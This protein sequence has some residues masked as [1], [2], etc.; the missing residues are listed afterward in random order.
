[1]K[2]SRVVLSALLFV[3]GGL[4]R[5]LFVGPVPINWDAVQF[6]L[7]VERFDLH[8][9]QPHAPGYILYVLMGRA[10]N[11]LV[12]DPSVSLALLSVLASALAAPLVYLSALD[13]L[14]D[15]AVALGAA[16]LV[17]GSPL[18]LYYGSVGLTYVPEMVLSAAVGWAAWRVRKAPSIRSAMVMGALLGVAGGVRQTSI[19]VLLPLCIWALWPPRSRSISRKAM[20]AFGATLVG[21]TLLW[22]V[23]LVALSG[24]PSA[25]L[26]E[27][28]LLAQTTSGQTSIFAVG[29]GGPAY[30]FTFEGLS[31]AVGLA[32]GVIPLGLWAARVIRFSLASDLK[33]LMAW[34]VLP[35][36]AFY[37]LTH[38]G[39]YGYVLVVLP[40]LAMLSALCAR[41]LVGTGARFASRAVLVCGVLSLPSAGYFLWAQGPTTASSISLNNTYWE[42][43]RSVLQEADPD[44]TVLVSSVEWDGPFR[45]AGYLLPVY[46]TYAYGDERVA[47][48]KRGWL[49]S[50]YGGLSDYVLPRPAPREYLE[51]PGGTKVVVGLDKATGEMLSREKDVQRVSLGGSSTL[52]M[53]DSSPSTIT[54]LIISG[55]RLQPVYGE[56]EGLWTGQ[57]ESIKHDTS[58]R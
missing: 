13:M 40:P 51:L 41:V 52:Y 49:Y 1:M 7:G 22:L 26:R 38:I 58:R 28:S 43:V 30:N 5:L 44:H 31:L 4:S 20:A 56:R 46:H 29:I 36:L 39:Q 37:G 57:K 45:H 33:G 23:P 8:M 27:N 12:G 32:F 54:G 53:L 42:G 14:D 16:L 50:A 48:G 10:I 19:V 35:A 15:H 24:G 3:A 21:V 47:N 34:W 6:A 25:Y 55:Q 11:L 2:T 18:A 17:L 9:H